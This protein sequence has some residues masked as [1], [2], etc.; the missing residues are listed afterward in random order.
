MG[1]N[2]YRWVITD[3]SNVG[4]ATVRCMRTGL[5]LKKGWEGLDG[6]IIN[7]QNKK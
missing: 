7:Q 5:W 1:Y 6:S 4:N 2:G 3:L